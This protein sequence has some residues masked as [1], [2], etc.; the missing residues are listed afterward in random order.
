ME[1]DWEHSYAVDGH[2]SPPSCHSTTALVFPEFRYLAAILG[3]S[4]DTPNDDMVIVHWFEAPDQYGMVPIS[5]S[6]IRKVIGN[7]HIMWMGS[8]ST[9]V[10][11]YHHI[12]WPRFQDV[13]GILW[14]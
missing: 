14:S 12:C 6:N 8:W 5:T 9:I 2:T 7:I 11:L 1:G 13:S 10:P 3:H 4:L